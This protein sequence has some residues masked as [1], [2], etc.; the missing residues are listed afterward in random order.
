M[1]GRVFDPRKTHVQQVFQLGLFAQ[2]DERTQAF[3]EGG[4]RGGQAAGLER[5]A[6]QLVVDGDLN[7]HDRP[8]VIRLDGIVH[9]PKWDCKLLLRF[10]SAP[11]AGAAEQVAG[12]GADHDDAVAEADDDPADHW[13]GR[14]GRQITFDET[15]AHQQQRAQQ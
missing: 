4:G 1:A 11:G 5:L 6:H 13:K 12:E 14:I 7:L 3:F 2:V 15:T 9:I 8:R 10:G